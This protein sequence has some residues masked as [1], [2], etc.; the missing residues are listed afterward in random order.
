VLYGDNGSA[1]TG[2]G[3]GAEGGAGGSGIVYIRYLL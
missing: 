3:G 2:G 1:N